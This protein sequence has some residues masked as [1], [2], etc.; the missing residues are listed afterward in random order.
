MFGK[1]SYG[2]YVIVVFNSNI[3]VF[4]NMGNLFLIGS[5]IFSMVLSNLSIFPCGVTVFCIPLSRSLIFF[6][7]HAHTSAT[8][9]ALIV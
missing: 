6:F 8:R 5:V 1:F 4:L 7:A 3:V 9:P 2:T